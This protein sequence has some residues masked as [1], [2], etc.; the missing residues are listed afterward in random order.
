MTY[1]VGRVYQV[2]HTEQCLL[3][4]FRSITNADRVDSHPGYYYH[5]K[6]VLYVRQ[7]AIG[8]SCCGSSFTIRHI[9]ATRWTFRTSYFRMYLRIS[10]SLEQYWRQCRS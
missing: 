6:S 10:A 4:A 5:S 2:E 8:V 1:N 9:G 7:L 3:L